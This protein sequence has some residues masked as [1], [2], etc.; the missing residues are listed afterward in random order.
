MNS[1]F[2]TAILAGALSVLAASNASAVTVQNIIWDPDASVGN[3]NQPA[4]DFI[5]KTTYTQWFQAA[6][7][8]NTFSARQAIN[9]SDLGSL[10]GLSLTG[11][12]IFA[13]F[14][15]INSIN[16]DPFPDTNPAD[17]ADNVQ[18]TYGFGGIVVTA[19]DLTNP[20]VPVFT[21]DYSNAWVN[22]YSDANLNYGNALPET[23][24]A[25]D[26]TFGTPF[27]TLKIDTLDLS[28]A[29]LG[30]NLFG[31][32]RAY[33]SVTGGAAADYFDTNTQTNASGGV[34]DLFYTSSSQFQDGDD[35]TTGTAEL[36]GDTQKLP[37]PASLALLGLGVLGLG[38]YSRRKLIA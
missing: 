31:D 15:G 9:T 7:A 36:S 25:V 2:S 3:P 35:F 30:S 23:S 14:N 16:G 32:V 38:K 33:F 19:V 18:L 20:A 13:E 10:A 11:T 24:D 26:S 22:L 1:K 34:S 12:G 28:T 5:G 6:S 8:E 37:E 27:L 29:V 21:L 4:D 17:F